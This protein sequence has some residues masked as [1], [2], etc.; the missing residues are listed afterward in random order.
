MWLKRGHTPHLSKKSASLQDACHPWRK[1]AW[2]C[3]H[4]CVRVRE[5]HACHWESV[6][7][8]RDG[9]RQ[10][11]TVRVCLGRSGVVD[12]FHTICHGGWTPAG[13]MRVMRLIFAGVGDARVGLANIWRS[14]IAC[15]RSEC[16]MRNQIHWDDAIAQGI[17]SLWFKQKVSS[18]LSWDVYC[19][20]IITGLYLDFNLYSCHSQGM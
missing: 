15:H 4:E 2:W 3:A 16:W 11:R 20:I 19:I 13:V 10:R 5:C 12:V 1:Q 18:S 8:C 6:V 7:C 9:R 17:G 14:L